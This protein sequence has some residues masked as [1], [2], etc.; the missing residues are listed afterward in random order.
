MSKLLPLNISALAIGI[1][2]LYLI[3]GQSGIRTFLIIYLE[4]IQTVPKWIV[5][6]IALGVQPYKNVSCC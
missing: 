5:G 4:K 1:S 3:G 6:L 2:T